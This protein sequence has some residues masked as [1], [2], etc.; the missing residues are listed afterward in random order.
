MNYSKTYFNKW[1]CEK[2]FKQKNLNGETETKTAKKKS[3]I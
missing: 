1:E 3:L 2:T